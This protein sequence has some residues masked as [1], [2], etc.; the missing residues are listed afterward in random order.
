MQFKELGNL[1]NSFGEISGKRFNSITSIS[2]MLGWQKNSFNEFLKLDSSGISQYTMEEIKA[3]SAVLGLTD[4]LTTQAVALAKD[5][6]F[7]AK[8]ST[9]KLTFKD[10][11]KDNK[12]SLT[13][14]GKALEKSDKLNIAWKE[15]LQKAAEAGTDAY[16]AEVR[17]I[18]TINKDV[19]DSI[20]DIGTSVQ[21]S[22]TSLSAYF[23]GMLASIKPLVPAIAAVAVAFAAFKAWDYSQHGFTRAVQDA[24]NAATEYENVKSNLESLNS[25]LDTTR[26]KI[27]ELQTLQKNGTI[28]FAQEVELEQLKSTNDELERQ[29][30]IQE[31]LLKIKQEASAQAAL[32]ASKQQQTYTEAMEKEYGGFW[33]KIYGFLTDNGGTYVSN[34]TGE[35]VKTGSKAEEWYSKYGEDSTV[36]GQVKANIKALE[37]YKQELVDIEKQLK[38]N[39]EDKNLI[40]TQDELK[41]KIEDTT[42]ALADQSST[43]QGWIDQSTDS[44][45][46]VA[47]GFEN[48]VEEWTNALTQIQNI[49]KSQKEIDLN[50]LNN[51]FSTSKGKIMKQYL[52]D[53]AK[54]SGS[55]EEALNAFTKTGISLEDINVSSDGFLR[56]FEDIVKSATDASDAISGF[57]GSLESIT[58]AGESANQDVNW[59]TVTDLFDKAKK[60]D[61]SKKWGTDD[62]QSMAQFIAPEG[63]IINTN[64]SNLK[65]TDY[66]DLWDKY[67]ANFK[68]YFD[69]ENPLQSAINAQDKLISSGL[70]SM[71][72]D[73]IIKWS[74]NFK[75][76]A[77]AAKAW[78]VSVEAAEIAMHNLESY[79]AEFDGVVFSK[80]KLDEYKTS[81]EGIRS[82]YESMD[83][84][85]NK[86]RLGKLI[87][88]FDSE[89]ANFEQDISKLSEDQI[90]R[91]KFEYDLASIQEEIDNIRSQI[92]SGNASVENFASV[93]AGND[94][95]IKK[96]KELLN[97]DKIEIPVEIQ[98]S[99]KSI[100]ETRKKMR[101]ATGDEKIQL[102]AELS[103]K[104]EVEKSLLNAFND[105]HPEITPD[106]DPSVVQQKMNEFFS[107][108]QHITVEADIVSEGSTKSIE[109]QLQ[110]LA[111]GS[112]ITFNAD[113]NGVERDVSAVKN[114]DG[115]IV[116]T[117]NVDGVE[118]PVEVSEK[119][120]TV[121]FHVDDTNVKNYT[122][123]QKKALV[124]YYGDT[125]SLPTSF[126][127]V[128]R[129]VLYTENGGAAESKL[130]W[131]KVAGKSEGTITPALALG[132]AYNVINT[133]PL[134]AFAKGNISLP[135]DEV[136]LV[137]E[138]GTEGLI[139][140]GKLMAI[141]GGIHM[142]ALKKGDIILS[143]AQMKA[144][145]ATGKASGHARAYASGTVLSSAYGNGMPSLG[146]SYSKS[147]SSTTTAKSTTKNTTEAKSVEK[148]V[149][150]ATGAAEELYNFIEILLTRTKE[151]TKKLTDAIEDAV[152]LSDKMSKNSSALSQIQ[153]EISVNQ[154]AY[155]K[156]IA[157][158]NAV[159]LAEGYASQ[160]RN[161]SL[162]IEN[163]T[164]ENLK[165]KIDQYKEYYDKAVSVQEAVRDLQ[166]EEKQLALD[167]LDYIKDYYDA[168]ENLNSAYRDVNDTR[169]ELNN[170]LG[171]S[172][173]GNEI[174]LLLQSSYEKQQD[175]YNKALTQLSD[176][177]NEFNEL[178]RNNYIEE[179]SEAYLEGQATIQEFI[180]QV[181]EAAIALIELEDKIRDI[182][183]KKLEQ[184]IESSERRSEQLKNAQSLAEARD[185]QIGREDYQ[186]QID[187]LSN[188][189]NQNYDLREQKLSEQALYD[190]GSDKYNE[191]A[192][193]ISDI[194]NEIYDNLIE[195]EELKD[196][197]FETEFINYEK[198]QE[199]LAYFIDELNDFSSLLNEDAFFTKD[200]AFT[201]EA[202]AKIALTADAMSKCKQQIANATE[203]LN[204][205]D[206]MYQNGLISEEEYNEK[207]KEL[208][209][210][211]RENTLAVDDYKNELIDLYKK[212]MEKENEALKKNI[213]LRKRA[214][215]AQKDYWDYADTI[216]SK[217]KDVDALKAQ[218]AALDGVT[219]SAGLARKK[220]LEAE[221]ANAEKDLS[222]TK[223]NHQYDMMQDGYDQMSENLD[224]SLEDLE[225]SIAT[226]SEKQL[227]I[228]QSMLNQMVASYQEA[229]GKINTIVNETGFVGT[230]SFNDT[231][232]NT[233]TSSGASSIVDNATQSQSTVKPSD[234]VSN[235]N[236]SNTSNTNTSAIESEIKKEPNTDNRLC[237]ELTL[238]KS[239]VSVQEGSSTSVS[240]SI[241]PND[242]KNKSLSWTPKDASVVSVTSDGKITGLKPGSTTIVVSTTDGS[243]LRQTVS[244]TVT[245]KPDPPKPQAPKN[246]TTTQGNGV[247]DVGDKVTFISGVYHED[248][249]GNG[250]WGNQGLGGSMYITKINPN[251]PYP[252]HLST[253]SKLG[254][255]DRGWLK[256][257]QIKGYARGSKHINGKRWALTQEKGQEL[258]ARLSDGSLLTPLGNGDKVFTK[259]QTDKLWEM[260]KNFNISD[261]VKLD[262]ES[263]FG[264]FSDFINRNDMRQ[265]SEIN[266]NFD[267]LLTIEG[268][269]TKDALPGLEKAIDKMIPHISDKLAIYLRGDMRK[270]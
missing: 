188:N 144:L 176:Y 264:K 22:T 155:N 99:E 105:A 124:K 149:K 201:D 154:Q 72:S 270:L 119:D 226:S 142:Q 39:P 261:Y 246:N 157:Q 7:T 134:S 180:K 216:N 9:G 75:T 250:R 196:K 130:A 91:I 184:L 233:S 68:K 257:N 219:S 214:L 235:I 76:S 108:P 175:S 213:E 42:T 32:N 248:S 12:N 66:K 165:K 1:F 114:E 167:R 197:I 63:S 55:A 87:E 14:I 147:Y 27:E 90:V 150:K 208:L 38:D 89:Y 73:G 71:S 34:M 178:V 172:A 239:S 218:I 60:L 11:L 225:Y 45:G 161:G 29:I 195:I 220:Q 151:L 232:N 137:N 152:S 183:Y 203:A 258:I 145:Y 111:S 67:Y 70:G 21:S 252:I 181:D 254:S 156:Y 84:S 212:Q 158:A 192:K 211:V 83:N 269:V 82:I 131:K 115:S 40:K 199:N 262:T 217:T 50:N 153:K 112:T 127:P 48:S 93:I 240:A 2:D 169:I 116:Y 56:Y 256:R 57:D 26:S 117:A 162:N 205:L 96:Q 206:E 128:Y 168:I 125:S 182:D 23:K 198:E 140:D 223:R 20:I 185:E 221:L 251:S 103:N 186:K 190:V 46:V 245:K 166:K 200:G 255:G 187:E 107:K 126:A 25:E 224:K 81:L 74:E 189:I 238:S 202:Y 85:A 18:I 244:V 259:E 204:K 86:D 65:A 135:Q 174:K 104:Q 49:G 79:G 141:P 30:A 80:E 260:S 215:Q 102:Q 4:E 231:V 43:L 106:T 77:D 47:K 146:G 59:N 122:P 210:T 3:K 41:T 97:F 16:E 171:K 61:E 8:A 28:T 253:G 101:T 36:T 98:A 44:N 110:N 138:F 58:T 228:V 78:G 100:E 54:S 121:T 243:N 95:Y 230:D 31:S 267:T 159:G 51:Y 241:R 191:L 236:S 222:D 6:D 133:K 109:E 143:V 69:S 37:E 268:N 179:G 229:Y 15:S 266:M 136:A 53:I 13:D 92:E 148:S 120:G 242:A 209:N 170:A 163:I 19:G 247:P 118:V 129:Q 237:A 139:R 10:A 173:V 33:G 62:F 132:S 207:Q 193:E 249:Y 94:T 194:D 164:D 177:Q 265:S 24:E 123:E 227:E 88:G 5:A 52:E 234:N 35:V 113:I 64:N 263:L 17:K 160:I